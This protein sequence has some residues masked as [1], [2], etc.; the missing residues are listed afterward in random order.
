MVLKRDGGEA[1]VGQRTLNLGKLLPR[2]KP[3]A[4]L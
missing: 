1:D 2:Q 4:E 3:D